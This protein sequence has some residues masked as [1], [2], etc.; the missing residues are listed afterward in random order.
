MGRIPKDIPEEQLVEIIRRLPLPKEDIEFILQHR[1]DDK[2]FL[3]SRQGRIRL[4]KIAYILQQLGYTLGDIATIFKLPDNYIGTCVKRYMA[5]YIDEANKWLQEIAQYVIQSVEF[6]EP[7]EKAIADVTR[8]VVSKFAEHVVRDELT[9]AWS[10]YQ[11]LR[12][13]EPIAKQMGKT[14]SQLAL[15]AISY[16][17]NMREICQKAIDENKIAKAM[18][19]EGFKRILLGELGRELGETLKK[20]FEVAE[21]SGVPL[22]NVDKLVDKLV[23]IYEKL[24]DSTYKLLFPVPG[25]EGGKHE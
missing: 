4:G 16:Y 23:R 18:I 9:T 24:V 5:D 1:G 21:A 12:P 11:T 14:L 20:L 19:K 3:H 10:L 22:E 13:F 17:L 25:L 2:F 15:D 8:K 7:T 6:K